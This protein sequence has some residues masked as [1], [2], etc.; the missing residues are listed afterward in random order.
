MPTIFILFHEQNKTLEQQ[1]QQSILYLYDA[2]H[3]KM[4]IILVTFILSGICGLAIGGLRDLPSFIATGVRSGSN[5][6]SMTEFQSPN[7]TTALTASGNTGDSDAEYPDFDWEAFHTKNKSR[8]KFGLKPFTEEAFLELEA[9]IKQIDT[10]QR[11]IAAASAAKMS[12][13]LKD[14]KPGFLETLV[15]NVMQDTCE[16]NYD[17][18]RPEVCCDFGLKKMCCSSGQMIRDGLRPPQMQPVRVIA[19]WKPGQGPP[20]ESY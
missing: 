4:K 6:I 13:Q 15:G 18:Q 16:S 9:A 14:N 12:K 20:P 5:S 8:K 19:G 11:A 3:P 2:R 7:P 1:R 10:Q 17:C